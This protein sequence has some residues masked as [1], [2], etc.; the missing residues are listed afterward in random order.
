MPTRFRTNFPGG[1]GVVVETD[2]GG[3][4]I[5]ADQRDSTQDWFYWCVEF[6]D[7]EAASVRICVERPDHLAMFGPAYQ[8]DD[9]AWAWAND[10]ACDQSEFEFSVGP[11]SARLRVASVK[12]Y[13][14]DNL[15]SWFNNVSR[16]RGSLSQ[17]VL[18]RTTQGKDLPILRVRS[19]SRGS[20]P[21]RILATARHHACETSANLVLEGLME[22][23]LQDASTGVEL[24]CIPFV[25]LDG[26]EEGDQGKG[27]EPHDHNRDYGDERIYPETAAIRRLLKVEERYDV[28]IDLHSPW[29]REPHNEC[30]HIVLP[31]PG[32][33]ERSIDEFSE[34]LE[35]RSCNTGMGF[36]R[37]DNLRF[38]QRWN[39]SSDAEG[40]TFIGYVR[41]YRCSDL[42]FTMEVPFAASHGVKLKLEDYREFGN[43]IVQSAIN[44]KQ[45]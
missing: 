28:V 36:R 38:G 39:R 11:N 9:G 7:I 40:S 8:V 16:T 5:G 4:H 13:S 3:F 44:S 41:K 22:Y 14:H 17:E 30:A 24:D 12:P 35:A 21:I 37:S 1:N 10:K 45:Y 2:D 33:M 6:N 18:C 25:D 29:I 23:V 19:P 32:D 26:V 15:V 43:N 31:K 20:K 27:R 42:A 34:W